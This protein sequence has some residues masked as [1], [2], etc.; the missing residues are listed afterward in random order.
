MTR[1][2]STS[3]QQVVA[4]LK[5]LSLVI[6]F[7]TGSVTWQLSGTTSTNQVARQASLLDIPQE[8]C[9]GVSR[10]IRHAEAQETANPPTPAPTLGRELPA[11]SSCQLEYQRVTSNRTKGITEQDLEQ[12]RALIGNRYRL[13]QLSAK[14]QRREERVNAV[15]CGG[16]ITIGHGVVP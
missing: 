11:T 14:L 7:V 4:T 3:S 16:S 13:S 12:S 8:L 2:A 10:H 15:V 6:F 1:Q 9:E 5:L